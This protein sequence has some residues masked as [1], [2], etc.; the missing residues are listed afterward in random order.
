MDELTPWFPISVNPIRQGWYEY[1]GPSWEPS[2]MLWNG[3]E[4][5]YFVGPNFVLM[6][7]QQLDQWRGL[8]SD[9]AKQ[10]GSL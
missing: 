5:G 10:A 7:D 2:R 6:L 8:A 4:W 9:P 1:R 3:I